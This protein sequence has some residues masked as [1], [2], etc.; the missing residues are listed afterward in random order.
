MKIVI[1]DWRLGG[2]LFTEFKLP[3]T[4]NQKIEGTEEDAVRIAG[5]CFSKGLNVMLTRTYTGLG[6]RKDPKVVDGLMVAI[7]TYRFVQRG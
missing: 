5:E 1:S 6:T 2:H 3:Y 4:Q 7:D